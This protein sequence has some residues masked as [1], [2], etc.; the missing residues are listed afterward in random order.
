MRTT[1]RRGAASS[2]WLAVTVDNADLRRLQYISLQDWGN[3]MVRG[4]RF[5][6]SRDLRQLIRDV[7]L[8]RFSYEV[9]SR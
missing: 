6:D 5:T 9:N 7:P 1:E 2:I 4:G 3:C 8:S